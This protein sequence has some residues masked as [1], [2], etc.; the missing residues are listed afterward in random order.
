MSANAQQSSSISDDRASLGHSHGYR[1]EG[2]IAFLNAELAI[3]ETL[4]DDTLDWAL[5]LWA[6]DAPYGGGPLH[7][8]K[9]AEAQLAL[10]AAL[11]AEQR[12]LT[13]EAFARLPPGQRSYAMVMV[14][15]SGARGVFD[16]VH[17]F[18]NYPSRQQ[19]SAPHFEGTVG[20][21]IEQGAVVLSAE[22]VKNPRAIGN[23]SG[24]LAV[25][26]WA[27]PAPYDGGE[28]S[29]CLLAH[30]ELDR[31]LGQSSHEDIARRV[32]MHEPPEGDWYLALMLREWTAAST[33]LTR[34]YCTFE[35]R[36]HSAKSGLPSDERAEESPRAPQRSSAPRPDRDVP[37]PVK[38]SPRPARSAEQDTSATVALSTI[39]IQHAS[40]E[41]LTSVPGLNRK[42]AAAIVRARPYASLDELTR[43]RGIGDRLLAKLKPHLAL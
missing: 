27:L 41:Q 5:Q 26:L 23:I 33:F 19:F 36:Y 12:Q 25:E 18:C 8:I 11:E 22:R 3:P 35:T 39:S 34:D 15:A 4:R 43:V 7:G 20:Y 10:P 28:V 29:G 2:D 1:V 24:T 37:T 13:A 31:L 40:I 42:L 21:R 16:Q 6:C 14:L 32:G 30:V 17:D 9:V 38:H